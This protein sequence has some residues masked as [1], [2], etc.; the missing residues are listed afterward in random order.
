MKHM[1]RYDRYKGG[2]FKDGT[3]KIWS[4][5]TWEDEERWRRDRHMARNLEDALE[6]E[7]GR[8][9]KM[10]E[11]VLETGRL[12][13]LEIIDVPVVISDVAC[14]EMKSKLNAWGDMK[15]IDNS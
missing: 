9:E 11:D 10:D 12:L 6:L 3:R 4:V 15:W 7:V 14:T 5:G 13:E 1:H 2:I 8:R